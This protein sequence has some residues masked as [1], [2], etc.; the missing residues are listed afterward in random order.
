MNGRGNKKWWDFSVKRKKDF[1]KVAHLV[2]KWK[3]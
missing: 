3:R 2:E 1:G